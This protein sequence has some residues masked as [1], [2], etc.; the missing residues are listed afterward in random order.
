M[1]K[2]FVW[3]LKIQ[4]RFLTVN[5]ICLYITYMLKENP[6]Q[7]QV[8]VLPYMFGTLSAR[9]WNKKTASQVPANRYGST[10]WSQG[11]FICPITRFNHMGQFTRSTVSHC[12]SLKRK[13]KKKKKKGKKSSE[14]KPN[15]HK[16]KDDANSV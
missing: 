5:A 16:S 15:P 7:F 2:V 9:R 13:Q 10:K 4:N 11:R 14:T 1:G 8:H 12:F 6:S 3:V